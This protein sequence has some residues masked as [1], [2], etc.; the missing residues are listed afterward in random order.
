M[1]VLNSKVILFAVFSREKLCNCFV[2]FISSVWMNFD[3][4]KYAH[5]AKFCFFTRHQLKRVFVLF[6][7]PLI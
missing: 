2:C 6:S 4:E 3:N 5:L 1:E 7:L